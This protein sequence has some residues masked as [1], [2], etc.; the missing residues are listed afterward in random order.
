MVMTVLVGAVWDD[1]EFL[2]LP[3]V[4]VTP[5]AG[6]SLSIERLECPR[7]GIGAKGQDK[8]DKLYVP[9]NTGALVA[10][11]TSPAFSIGGG[12]ELYDPGIRF[13]HQQWGVYHIEENPSHAGLVM[14]HS[15]SDSQLFHMGSRDSQ[16]WAKSIRSANAFDAVTGTRYLLWVGSSYPEENRTPQ[17]TPMA[18]RTLDLLTFEGFLWSTG[19]LP[20]GSDWYDLLRHYR[21]WATSTPWSFEG[22]P[23]R[24]MT[25]LGDPNNDVSRIVKE[26]ALALIYAGNRASGC[27][28]D[29]QGAMVN[30]VKAMRRLFV[31]DLQLASNF[32]RILTL[33]YGHVSETVISTEAPDKFVDQTNPSAL[34][35]RANGSWLSEVSNLSPVPGVSAALYYFGESVDLLAPSWAGNPALSVPPIPPLVGPSAPCPP[36]L[37]CL[38][39]WPTAPPLPG[40]RFGYQVLETG[41][42]GNL[43]RWRD[44]CDDAIL[45]CSASGPAYLDV[46]WSTASGYTN[47]V[48]QTL[49][50]QGDFIKGIY[51]DN[52]FSPSVPLCYYRP[53]TNDPEDVLHDHP[54][55]GGRYW[56]AGKRRLIGATRA[57]LR[58][59]I[60]PDCYVISEQQ[61]EWFIGASDVTGSYLHG[62]QSFFSNFSVGAVLVAPWLTTPF[63]TPPD[64]D[65]VSVPG[66]ATVYADYVLSYEWTAQTPERYIATNFPGPNTYPPNLLPTGMP[67]PEHPAS[68][69]WG[70][71]CAYNGYNYTAMGV[72]DPALCPNVDVGTLDSAP[73]FAHGH[74]GRIGELPVSP[75]S[76]WE[77][78]MWVAAST[79]YAHDATVFHYKTQITSFNFRSDSPLY[80]YHGNFDPA[81]SGPLVADGAPFRFLRGMLKV[82][83]DW[84]DHYM[85][86]AR[87]GQ[88]VIEPLDH[89][90]FV[91]RYGKD[92]RDA[93]LV[94]AHANPRNPSDTIIVVTNWLPWT[95]AFD[96]HFDPTEV[97]FTA[98]GPKT[99]TESEP[100]IG[101][102]AMTPTILATQSSSLPGRLVFQTSPIPGAGVR[103][104]H[105]E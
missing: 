47:L 35:P 11:Y 69:V 57:A 51:L 36:A 85:F 43:F 20:A 30:D 95:V 1:Y 4:E 97:G 54:Q 78:L 102:G 42:S 74:I 91:E 83:S 55:G 23:A 100:D 40:I 46:F 7:L 2:W 104:Y 19:A 22:E 17:S 79:A 90:D 77:N 99:I 31:E 6:S 33:S 87:L 62:S 29:Y 75:Q 44:I 37:A 88:P 67:Y 27:G 64:H 72:E 71:L 80:P 101:E 5:R 98:A 18:Y 65:I 9:T 38:A 96:V 103:V 24:V 3:M 21:G 70:S 14:D 93:A 26:S 84:R 32:S 61:T 76:R 73:Y 41:P 34:T 53:L 82:K 58:Q 10:N 66:F 45:M 49:G 92:A 16:G 60:D 94:S 52:M 39:P 81:F 105:L 13:S 25:P 63:P 12:G 56:I 28:T 15:L 86:G 68:P 89:H 59:G 48:R 50:S 8:T